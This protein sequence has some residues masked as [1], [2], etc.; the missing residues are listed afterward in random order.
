MTRLPVSGRFASPVARS[1]G[2]ATNRPGRRASSSRATKAAGTWR[3]SS[4]RCW[5][6]SPPMPG[7]G[8]LA[9]RC[10]ALPGERLTQRYTGTGASRYRY[11]RGEFVPALDGDGL[12][13]VTRYEGGWSQEV[14][15]EPDAP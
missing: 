11:A 10:R 5:T 12:G 13:L 15:A 14:A 2:A 8:L 4:P 1:S 3:E 7:T 6:A 9:V